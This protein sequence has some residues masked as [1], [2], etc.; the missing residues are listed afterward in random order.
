METKRYRPRRV[1]RRAQMGDLP[2]RRRGPL[3]A[4]G[5]AA[6]YRVLRKAVAERYQIAF[7]ARLADLVT[8]SEAAW[9]KGF[10]HFIACQHVDFV[11][12]DPMAAEFRRAI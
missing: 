8:C 2:Y 6:L 7:K 9:E 3:L 10:G 12:C 5:E 4:R 1:P 11:L